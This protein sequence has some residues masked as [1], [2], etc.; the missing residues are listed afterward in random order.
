MLAGACWAG[1]LLLLVLLLRERRGHPPVA[2]ARR[3]S[4]MAVTAIG[5]VVASG[6]I[7]AV[8]ELGGLGALGDTLQTSYGRTLAIKVAVVL[9]VLGVGAYNRTRRGA[10]AGD[11]PPTAAPSRGRGARR[12]RRDPA[13]DRHPDELRP[14][15]GTAPASAG[16]PANTVVITGSDFATTIDVT[17]SVT[18]AQPGPNLFRADVTAYG[19]DQAVGA[20]AVTIRMRSVTRPELP[21]STLALRPDGDRWVAQALDPSVEG[22]YRLRSRCEPAHRSP[23][24]RSP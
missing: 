12:H 7:R 15:R 13:A 5:I 17:V 11:G 16:A 20:D 24:F 9:A 14:A 1:G 10:P 3:Y 23:R 4:N 8:A 19:T 22:T 21:A 2:E 18:P 6:I